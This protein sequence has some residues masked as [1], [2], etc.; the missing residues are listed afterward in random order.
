MKHLCIIGIGSNINPEEN[1]AE[2][3]RILGKENEISRVSRFIKTAP[4]GVTDQPDFLNGAVR[5]VT[6]KEK[7]NFRKYLKEVEDLLKRDR[8]AP[9]FGPRSIDLDIVVW[10]GEIIDN[11]YYRREFLKKVVDEIS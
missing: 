10:D 5:V 9:K 8:S 11:D 6:D 7:N 3:L 4:I 1:I 2:A